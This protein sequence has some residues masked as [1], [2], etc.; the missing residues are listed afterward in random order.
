MPKAKPHIVMRS[1][2]LIWRGVRDYTVR[3]ASGTIIFV[4][5]NRW[6]VLA[7]CIK[8]EHGETYLG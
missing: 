8:T 1:S 7:W 2:S 3:C 5:T 4:T 6:D